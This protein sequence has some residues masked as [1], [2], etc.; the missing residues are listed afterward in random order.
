MNDCYSFKKKHSI[1]KRSTFLRHQNERKTRGTI[2]STFITSDI[3]TKNL[4]FKIV[5]FTIFLGHNKMVFG[6]LF[7]NKMFRSA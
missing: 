1:L 7:W 6:C 3:F 2:D 5:I 4:E